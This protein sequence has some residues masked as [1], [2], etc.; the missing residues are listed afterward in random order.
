MNPKILVIGG[1]GFIGENV[2]TRAINLGWES[3]SLSLSKSSLAGVRSLQC[4]TTNSEELSQLLKGE[5]FDYIVNCAGNVNHGAYFNGG[6]EQ[7][8]FHFISLVNIINSIDR[9][10][11]KC[12]INL[13][14]SDEY[15]SAMAP[16]SEQLRELPNS[17]YAMGKVASSHFL[18]MLHRTEGFP[19]VTLRIFLTYGPGQRPNRLIPQTI[20]AC[21]EK[22]NFPT[23]KGDQV[24]DFCYIDDVVDAIFTS[25]T[26]SN[27][28]GFILNVGSGE[29]VPVKNVILQ[30]RSIIGHG[31]PQFGSI[32]S[33]ALENAALY[34]DLDLIRKVLDWIP[35]VTLADGLARTISSYTPND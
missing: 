9:T 12:F 21:I 33:R 5:K 6:R 1:T 25:L 27:A 10:G 28:L 13:G 29:P 4:D 35:R 26:N 8:N 17:P 14:S 34:P 11:L 31:E 19:A 32:E 7:I 23:S 30:I 24:R 18:Q 20:Q 16:Q 15:G 3:T 22:S 2:L